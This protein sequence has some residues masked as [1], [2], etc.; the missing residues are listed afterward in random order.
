[1]TLA[2]KDVDPLRATLMLYHRNGLL[3]VHRVQTFG[4]PLILDS[5]EQSPQVVD[6]ASKGRPMGCQSP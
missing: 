4:D 5:T 3:A 6:A 1:M 2:A